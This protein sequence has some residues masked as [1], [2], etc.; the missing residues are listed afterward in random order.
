[1]LIFF[2]VCLCFAGLVQ[3][4]CRQFSLEAEAASLCLLKQLLTQPHTHRQTLTQPLQAQTQTHTQ[5]WS[6]QFHTAIVG[7]S[8][9]TVIGLLKH[10]IT[11][12]TLHPQHYEQI[13]FVCN[14]V[15]KHTDTDEEDHHAHAITNTLAHT[16][17]DK[18]DNEEGDGE[19]ADTNI[20]Y[21][22]DED[23]REI[24]QMILQHNNKHKSALARKH[25]HTHQQRAEAQS[26]VHHCKMLI[27]LTN[28]L[29][30]LHFPQSVIASCPLF[31]SSEH[32]HV[33]D[34]HTNANTNTNTNTHTDTITRTT[35]SSHTAARLPV[36]PLLTHSFD[37]L[38]Y[39][40]IHCP[41]EAV[42]LLPLHHM[43]NI[44][45]EEFY[46][47][48]LKASY[49]RMCAHTHVSAGDQ[50]HTPTLTQTHSQAHTQTNTGPMQTQARLEFIQRMETEDEMLL[51]L[52]NAS[53]TLTVQLWTLIYSHEE[54]Q[55]AHTQTQQ[56]AESH[57]Q[58]THTQSVS[59]VAIIIKALEN[60]LT[61]LSS[62]P[63]DANTKDVCA[64]TSTGLSLKLL[65]YKV[66]ACL[67]PLRTNIHTH[68]NS[69]S[70]NNVLSSQVCNQLLKQIPQA[71]TH[72]NNNLPTQ[73]AATEDHYC[74]PL[75]THIVE[76]TIDTCW[77]LHVSA[78]SSSASAHCVSVYTLMTTAF[79]P[80]TTGAH[81][82]M[83]AYIQQ[84]C[85][86]VQQIIDA[87]VC[88]ESK[89]VSSHPGGCVSTH[90]SKVFSAVL[91]H[92]ITRLLHHELY[93]QTP[94]T[95]PTDKDT[96]TKQTTKSKSNG[97]GKAAGAGVGAVWDLLHESSSAAGV[98]VSADTHTTSVCAQQN[99]VSAARRHADIFA[100]FSLAIVLLLAMNT[101]E[102]ERV[103]FDTFVHTLV[104]PVLMGKHIVAGR[105]NRKVSARARL[106]AIHALFYI[107]SYVLQAHP[108]T[109]NNSSNSNSKLL[110][111]L[112]NEHV[113]R[114]VFAFLFVLAEQLE[115]R[116]LGSE[117]SLA[118]ALGVRTLLIAL[119]IIGT[120]NAQSVEDVLE[121]VSDRVSGGGLGLC[122]SPSALVRT[123]LHDEGT[124]VEA[125]ELARDL[126]FVCELLLPDTLTNT[127]TN[128]HANV[129]RTLVELWETLF[130]HC[131]NPCYDYE[132]VCVQSLC[133]LYAT[134]MMTVLFPSAHID[135]STCVRTHVMS[136]TQSL[137]S[138][139]MIMRRLCELCVKFTAN[140]VDRFDNCVQ[141]AGSQPATQGQQ[142]PAAI[143]DHMFTLSAQESASSI[144]QDVCL[145]M[146]QVPALWAFLRGS[147]VCTKSRCDDVCVG[148]PSNNSLNGLLN[149]VTKSLDAVMN[150]LNTADD[151]ESVNGLL[152]VP[153]FSN[154]GKDLNRDS[155]LWTALTS[156]IQLVGQLLSCNASVSALKEN[157]FYRIIHDNKTAS[158]KLTTETNQALLW[159][160][161]SFVSNCNTNSTAFDS[162]LLVAEMVADGKNGDPRA[163]R[164]V[165]LMVAELASCWSVNIETMR[166]AAI[167]ASELPQG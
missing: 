107:H 129:V 103:G 165:T 95:Q 26:F 114:C 87:C 100:S 81:R 76:H 147:I 126:V 118:D 18:D 31:G 116:I 68:P 36:W 72:T 133:M 155:L 139:A 40:F 66:S 54:E 79:T 52:T 99:T 119:G 70:S 92:V 167:V 77:R 154:N 156:H 113:V 13:L 65:Q 24:T 120:N 27:D 162:R 1:V 145:H 33:G 121:S 91:Q 138:N 30:A 94:D 98:G 59:A 44:S 105:N 43:L 122:V 134:R 117:E 25:S 151:K 69:N 80:T 7:V 142:Q 159:Y 125:V 96:G 75:L 23:T 73:P 2:C 19:N 108:Y 49:L 136:G 124:R 63:T 78:A 85:A 128:A 15:L 143:R 102:S 22:D 158:M 34:T 6:H 153:E 83:C 110:M 141:H 146:T 62:V 132:H 17:T 64:Q 97:K 88:I 10:A 144:Y 157:L 131:C 106:R 39:L 61:V 42:K 163:Q 8:E 67:E 90:T 149:A 101:R 35:G 9:Q 4:Y 127:H 20:D 115:C 3:E 86:A 47:R 11:A 164:V 130:E 123:W 32:T 82:D 137:E 93:E 55:L 135:S 29:S 38:E 111:C 161:L 89:Y 45:K 71:N 60:A 58:T 37:V 50:T 148:A 166:T 112:C 14:Y 28:F 104:L 5:K 150:A 140:A 160:L 53:P 56:T 46:F 48:K 74:W 109:N 41:E 57:T 21:V 152:R 51:L 12:H 84:A 16:D